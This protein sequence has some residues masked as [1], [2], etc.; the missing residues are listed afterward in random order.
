ML[1]AYSEEMMLVGI[2][3]GAFRSDEVA[4]IAIVNT[5]EGD[6]KRATDGGV[7]LGSEAKKTMLDVGGRFDLTGF[8]DGNEACGAH[9]WEDKEV[10][11]WVLTKDGLYLSVIGCRL[12]PGDVLLEE[13]DLH[14]ERGK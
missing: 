1:I 4:A 10:G 12:E 13:G 7:I 14:E 11:I 9:L 8:G 3:D 2:V 5:I 6:S